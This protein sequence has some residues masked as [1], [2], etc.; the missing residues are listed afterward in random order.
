MGEVRKSRE[1]L[2]R[3]FEKMRKAKELLT[4]RDDFSINDLRG[5]AMRWND[6]L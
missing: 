1:M 4:Q 3:Y 2:K 5:S 6:I